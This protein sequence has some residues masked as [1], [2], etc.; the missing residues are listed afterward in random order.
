[1]LFEFG[2]DVLIW[3]VFECWKFG[4]L[5]FICGWWNGLDIGVDIFEC[6]LGGEISCFICGIEVGVLGLIWG[7]EVCLGV[8][9]GFGEG[10]VVFWEGIL[11]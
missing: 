4:L 3:I 9:G 11:G 7:V 5:L 8:D 6:G 2:R 10:V 1:M